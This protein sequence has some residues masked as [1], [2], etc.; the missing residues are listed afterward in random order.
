MTNRVVRFALSD[1]GATAALGVNLTNAE[2]LAKREAGA[3]GLL[4]RG[5][6][7]VFGICHDYSGNMY[8]TDSVQHCV[9]RIDEGGRIS[10]FAGLPGTAGDVLGVNASARFNTPKG[11]VCDRSGNVF[12]A[13]SE[14]NKI[15]IIAGGSVNTVAGSSKGNVNGV[16]PAAKFNNPVD[17]AVDKAGTL[18]VAD[19]GNHS[20][21][22]I[23]DGAA[24]TIAGNG[25]AGDAE[26]VLAS[27]STATFSSP[28]GVTVD[29]SGNVYV[30]DNANRKIKKVVPNG[31]VYLLS[32]SGAQGRS[33]GTQY[34]ESYTCS[35]DNLVSCD[36]DESGNL[37]VIDLGTVSVTDTRLIKVDYNGKPGVIAEFSATNDNLIVRN[38]MCTPGQKILITSATTV[39]EYS[40]SSSSSSSVDSSSS[41]SVDSSSSSS[42]SSSSVDSSSSSNSSNSSS[43][44]SVD[45]SSSSSSSSA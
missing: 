42:S 37:Y 26:N 23:K 19:L 40:S 30:L 45:S 24:I 18:Y 17:V 9:L 28:E 6:T 35:Y 21:R 11:I 33:L 36:V 43:S 44:S 38:V 8:V 2:V 3:T 31:W 15:K 34:N 32:G 16:G 12:V 5:G 1:A 39:G 13:D 29:A 22:R 27:S 20:L 41:S 7:A 10:I 25:T 14:N 4:A